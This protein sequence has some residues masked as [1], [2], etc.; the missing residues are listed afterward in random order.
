MRKII[1]MFICLVAA[2]TANAQGWYL[3]GEIGVWRDKGVESTNFSIVPDF[4]YSFND[5]WSVGAKLGFNHVSEP[6]VSTLTIDAYAR[7]T[8]YSKGMVSLYADAGAGIG[9]I[10]ADGFQAGITPGIAL[11]LNEHFSILATLGYLGYRDE[12]MEE[13]G[14]GF[15]MKSSDLKF[16]FYYS[17]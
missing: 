11:K 6:K 10:D 8:Y 1:L 13:D 5:K 14:F 15:H 7:Y 3:G 16:G 9:T 17:F 12:Y 4:G 2:I